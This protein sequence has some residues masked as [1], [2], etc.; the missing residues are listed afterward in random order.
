MRVGG[1]WTLIDDGLS[2]NGSFVNGERTRGRRRLQ[3]GDL[4]V[5]GVTSVRF[6]RRRATRSAPT[7]NSTGSREAPS[8]TDAQRRILIALCR[9]FRDGS[10]FSRPATNERIAREV[11]LSTDAVKKHLRVLFVRFGVAGLPQNEKRVRLAEQALDT[12][13]VCHTEL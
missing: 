4:L 3:D 13:A 9:P 5:F 1:E 6:R 11:F 7:A 8:L 10:G 2:K 12:G